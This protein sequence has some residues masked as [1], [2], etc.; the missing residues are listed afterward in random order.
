ML[1]LCQSLYPAWRERGLLP[2]RP[3]YK[4]KAELC[5]DMIDNSRKLQF[6]YGNSSLFL[7]RWSRSWRLF[8]PLLHQFPHL[9]SEPG[10]N[11]ADL[12][13]TL[14]WHLSGHSGFMFPVIHLLKGK[15]QLWRLDYAL[16]MTKK[17][18]TNFSHRNPWREY[19][20]DN[21]DGADWCNILSSCESFACVANCR[22]HYK[23]D[24]ADTLRWLCRSKFPQ[25]DSIWF[26]HDWKEAMHDSHWYTIFIFSMFWY[27]RNVVKDYR[28]QSAR[29]TLSLLI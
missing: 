29:S 13:F 15:T 12:W 8:G 27:I 5:L 28:Y 23:I 1:S 3:S 24:I 26:K 22:R 19:K 20:D 18:R 11:I 6:I 4:T 2:E 21:L 10:I 7:W 9:L 16:F 25:L 17:R 14:L